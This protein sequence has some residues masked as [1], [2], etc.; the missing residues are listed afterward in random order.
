MNLQLSYLTKY[1]YR[2]YILMWNK[3]LSI[4][5]YINFDSRK[6][7]NFITFEV[8]KKKKNIPQTFELN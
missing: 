2:K 8:K 5:Y 6:N 4:L 7:S 3:L 1:F